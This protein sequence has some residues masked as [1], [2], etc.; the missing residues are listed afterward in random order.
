MRPQV[1]SRLMC[2]CVSQASWT[3][4]AQQQ[5]SIQVGC[6]HVSL[7]WALTMKPSGMTP[8][9]WGCSTPGCKAM[10]TL[11]CYTYPPPPPHANPQ[12]LV[13]CIFTRPLCCCS[14]HLLQCPLSTSSSS[15]AEGLICT[16]LS[17]PSLSCPVLIGVFPVLPAELAVC[18]S[19][20]ILTLTCLSCSVLL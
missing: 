2:V 4:T 5:V 15:P 16:S 6:C 8:C 12:A 7:M 11:R 10:P 18:A 3:C 19:S 20:S 17:L 13:P 14:V 1:V 9:T